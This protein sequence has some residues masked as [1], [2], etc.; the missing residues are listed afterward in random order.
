M[1]QPNVDIKLKIDVFKNMPKVEPISYPLIIRFDN[2]IYR[3]T[4]KRNSY[5][6]T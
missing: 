2:K 6:T 4:E 3:I 1:I 5:D